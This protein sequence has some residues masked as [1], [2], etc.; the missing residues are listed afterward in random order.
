MRR[1]TRRM[2]YYIKQLTTQDYASAKDIFRLT[3][4]QEGIPLS[5]FGYRWRNRSH[6]DSFGIYTYAGDLLGFA[7]MSDGYH[8]QRQQ[9]KKDKKTIDVV[10]RYLSF[11]AVHPSYRGANLG[12]ELLKVLLAKAVADN[13]SVCLYPLENQRLKDWY[14]NNGFN[15]STHEYY[16]FHCHPTRRQARYLNQLN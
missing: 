9:L 3:F 8:E 13:K 10:S 15:P 7:T 12:S 1:I 4:L 5:F 6:E 2:T 14:K 16:N 11:L